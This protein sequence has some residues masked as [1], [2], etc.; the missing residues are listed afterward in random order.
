MKTLAVILALSIG[1]CSTVTPSQDVTVKSVEYGC[2]SASAA[3]KVINANFAKLSAG[4]RAKVAQAKAVTDP[5]CLQA[6]VPT[7]TGT[8]KAAFDGAVVAFTSVSAEASK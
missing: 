1:A 4:T 7:V 2:A 5:I 6:T 3:L 8:A